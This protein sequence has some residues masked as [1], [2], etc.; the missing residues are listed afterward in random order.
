M[1]ETILKIERL[2]ITNFAPKNRIVSFKMDCS[3]DN[4][5]FSIDRNFN[6]QPIEPYVENLIKEVKAMGKTEIVEDEDILGSIFVVRLFNED[7]I[8]E[9]LINFFSKVADKLKMMR[10]QRDHA[11]YMKVYDEIK[12]LKLILNDDAL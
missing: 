5:H 3:K 11:N 9:R 2:D 1:R 12:V 8:K 7:N 6:L 4:Q 10:H